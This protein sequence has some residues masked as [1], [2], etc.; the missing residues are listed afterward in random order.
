[1]G[2]VH[3]RA[4]WWD[5]EWK[6]PTE[7]FVDVANQSYATLGSVRCDRECLF[8]QPFRLFLHPLLNPFA[9]A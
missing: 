4:A 6:R 7:L 5:A 3:D 8:P 1:L 2:I 9:I